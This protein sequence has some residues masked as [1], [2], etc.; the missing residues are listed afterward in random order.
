MHK[1][2]TVKDSNT[3]VLHLGNEVAKNKW[4]DLFISNHNM[5][6]HLILSSSVAIDY[7]KNNFNGLYDV[8][9]SNDQDF[10]YSDAEKILE[11]MYTNNIGESAWYGAGY[12]EAFNKLIAD[13]RVFLP[14][15]NPSFAIYFSH[16]NLILKSIGIDNI[17]KNDLAVA[18]VKK[19]K[20]SL[21]DRNDV[22][23]HIHSVK[24]EVF[25]NYIV[26]HGFAALDNF[27]TF[28]VEILRSLSSVSDDVKD[29]LLEIS[30]VNFLNKEIANLKVI[31]QHSSSH[32]L[33]KHRIAALI[34][35]DVFES[36]KKKKIDK[37]SKS[38]LITLSDAFHGVDAF[39]NTP[40]IIMRSV[41]KLRYR[42]TDL[43][44]KIIKN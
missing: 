3:M 11:R 19:I 17:A 28:L 35:I 20:L 16:D 8:V 27:V 26:F 31:L 32:P 21:A 10:F 30:L 41:V 39:E 38:D 36:M 4:D 18:L 7:K 15:H 9:L 43:V 13:D 14:I 44:A 12:K 1:N 34:L 25:N 5:V 42:F 6:S 29:K 33:Y 40:P 37:L 2:L 23:H 24:I 22:V